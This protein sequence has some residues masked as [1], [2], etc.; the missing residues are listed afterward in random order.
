MASADVWAN[1]EI[2]L[3]RLHVRAEQPTLAVS[4]LALGFP[5]GCSDARS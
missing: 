2:S 5:L 4:S 1:L 3:R